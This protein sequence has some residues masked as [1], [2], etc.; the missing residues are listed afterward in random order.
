MLKTRFYLRDPKLQQTTL[1]VFLR[2]YFKKKLQE[3]KVSLHIT[4]SSSTWNQKHQRMNEKGNSDYISKGI[5][6]KINNLKN[7]IDK[8]VGLSMMDGKDEFDEVYKFLS[9]DSNTNELLLD[10]AISEYLHNLTCKNSTKV[11]QKNR[12][13]TFRDFFGNKSISG[14]NRKISM[15]FATFVQSKYAPNTAHGHYKVF[16]QFC[17]FLFKQELISKFDFEKIS[18]E[19]VDSTAL[20]FEELNTLK[21]ID[22]SQSLDNIRNLFMIMCY[23]GVRVSDLKQLLESNYD[24]E[25]ISFKNKKTNHEIFIPVTKPL[26]EYLQKKPTLISDQK[27]NLGLKQ[28]GTLAEIDKK[29]TNHTARRTF[30]TLSLQLGVPAELVMKVT[31]HTSAGILQKYIRHNKVYLINEVNKAWKR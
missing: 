17:N 30:V 18:Q 21:F 22:L 29:I 10:D 24:Q 27:I 23:S 16:K 1:Y 2:R 31:G 12:I 25:M 3:K 7:D 11:V 15:N 26:K 13:K 20:N 8:I 19:E 6:L 14:I 28:L 4:V 5:N 9:R